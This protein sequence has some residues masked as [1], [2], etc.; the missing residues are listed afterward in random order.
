[1][2][3]VKNSKVIERPADQETYEMFGVKFEMTKADKL[4][5]QDK[6][7]FNI[8]DKGI[9][10]YTD[11]GVIPVEFDLSRFRP[12]DVPILISDTTKIKKLGFGIKHTLEDIIRDQLN[13][14][15]DK[16]NRG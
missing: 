13:Y 9:R 7:E 8:E 15:M 10:V 1:V 5:L 2:E 3:T 16:G 6:I 4:L 11:K 12:A 14:F